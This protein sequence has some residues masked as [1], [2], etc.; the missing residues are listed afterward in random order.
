MF[1]GAIGVGI[2]DGAYEVNIASGK[3][4]SRYQK[5][6]FEAGFVKSKDEFSEHQSLI[7]ANLNSYKAFPYRRWQ[8]GG[9]MRLLRSEITYKNKTSQFLAIPISV[10]AIYSIPIKK[11]TYIAFS[12]FFA[13]RFITSGDEFE[14]F[15]EFNIKL[16]LILTRSLRGYLVSKKINFKHKDDGDYEFGNFMLFGLRY[17]F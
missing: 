6:F 9:G 8:V 2:G 14:E 7:F 12:Y 4:I 16:D 3:R 1:G 5:A 10:H 11:R 13:P 17:I 15:K